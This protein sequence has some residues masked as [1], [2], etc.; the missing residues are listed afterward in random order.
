[1][2]KFT[3]KQVADMLETNPETVRRWIRSGELK[4]EKGSN[5]TGNVITTDSL[6]DFG[7]AKPKYRP[8]I[9]PFITPQDILRNVRN[10]SYHAKANDEPLDKRSAG[11]TN[12]LIEFYTNEIIKQTDKLER[13]L[14]EIHK[15][16]AKLEKIRAAAE[17]LEQEKED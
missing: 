17:Q 2:G 10:N 14:K 15:T 8:N 11:N 3:V 1:M 9:L 5:K 4:A 7:N 12:K 13:L 6:V 16:T